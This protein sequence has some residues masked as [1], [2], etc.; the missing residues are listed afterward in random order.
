MFSAHEVPLGVRRRLYASAAV[1]VLGL[2]SLLAWLW[3]LQ[4]LRG[5]ELAVLSENNRIRLRRIPATRGRVVDQFKR[6]LVD[7]QASFDA[8]LVPEDTPDLE[9]TVET[10]AHFLNQTAGETRAVLGRVTGRPPFQEIL[11]KRDL[12][13]E[14]VVAIETH[15]LELPGVSLRITPRRNYP[16]GPLL[17]HVLGYVGE[18]SQADLKRDR[19]YRSGDLVGKSGLEKVW[20]Q[21]LRG[22]S[23]GQQ[24]EV[25]ALGRE[26]RVL[27]EVAA[28]PGNTLTLSI[29]L[30]LQ[31]AAE[32]ALG[33]QAG[34][35]VALDP[36]TGDLLAMVSHPTFDP[37]R[38]THRIDGDE[39]RALI[40]HPRRPLT[41]RT[42]QGQYPPGSTFK[43]VVAAAA[44]EE[45]II[46]PFTRLHCAGKLHFGQRDFRCWKKGGHGSVNV[47]DAL[48]QSCDVFF[49]H[50]GQRLGVDTIAAYARQFGLGLPTGIELEH[51]KSGTV[52]DSAWKKRRFGERWYS[53]ETLLVA[54]GQGYVTATPLQMAQAVATLATGV[55]FRPRLVQRIEGPDGS[56]V[57]EFKSHGVARLPFRQT[58]LAQVHA[59]LTD[60]V[61]DRHGTGK[62]AAL[63]HVTVAGKTGTSQVV[64]MGPERTDGND[65]PWEQRDHAWFVAYAPAEDPAVALT[66][67]VEHAGEGGGKAA[68]PIARDVLDV[69]F[70]LREQRGL[71]RYAQN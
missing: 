4:V 2:V 63:S 46:N 51:E 57:R 70:R 48:V 40:D 66:V 30:D 11:V 50:V 19:R 24:I 69:F 6:V 1:A 49:Y 62:R 15:Q 37:N 3:T 39:W 53:G 17:A 32:A 36:G 71:S 54:I 22:V 16:H 43:F 56:L 23:G 27:E 68:A 14:E 38:F 33:E 59:A 21:S 26:L 7:S 13:W 58:G 45:G 28:I 5:E 18:V 64:G 44:L 8:L 35:V 61:N 20:D 10:L 34:S 52:P 12:D 29:D 41:D 55:R 60:V 67:L 31:Q 65:V 42:T 47:H 25:D 9:N